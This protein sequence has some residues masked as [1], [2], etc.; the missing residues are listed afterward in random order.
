MLQFY[1]KIRGKESS[2]ALLLTFDIL[3]AEYR[4]EYVVKSWRIAFINSPPGISCKEE[5]LSVIY[6]FMATVTCCDLLTK[7]LLKFTD[8]YLIAFKFRQ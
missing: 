3:T 1:L 6:V 2:I 8:S 4:C 7:I 5:N